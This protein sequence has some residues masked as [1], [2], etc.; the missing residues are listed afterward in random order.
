MKESVRRIIIFAV[1]VATGTILIVADIPLIYLIPLILAVGFVLLLLLGAISIADLRAVFSRRQPKNLKPPLLPGQPGAVN[2]PE[3]KNA[4]LPAPVPKKPDKTAGMVPEKLPEKPAGI[5]QHLGSFVTSVR[6]IGRIIEERGKHAKKIEDIDRLLDNTVTEKVKGSALASAGEMTSNSLIPPGGAGRAEQPA[7]DDPFISLSGDELETGLLD[8]LDENEPPSS[9]VTAPEGTG[10]ATSGESAPD[11]DIPPDLEIPRLPE[12]VASLEGEDS[13]DEGFGDLD[14]ISIE[15]GD[16]DENFE[17]EKPAPVP[18]DVHEPPQS[19]DASS[20]LVPPPP[21]EPLP[22]VDL[23]SKEEDTEGEQAEMALFD[24]A[25]GRDADMLSSLA[26][27]IKHVKKELDLSLLRDLKDFKAPAS[28]IESELKDLYDQI[29][30]GNNEGKRE[31]TLP[32]E[33]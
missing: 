2:L 33:K 29:D 17:T 15:D 11:L 16:L 7:D 12:D 19:A 25:S 21:I 8:A 24:V 10:P 26:S 14:G 32:P 3:K 4:P 1:I 6:S 27:D 31:P 20:D 22:P 28:E 18:Q 13:M 30:G 9:S 5:R 23:I